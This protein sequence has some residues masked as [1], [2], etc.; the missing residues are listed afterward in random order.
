MASYD[1][2]IVKKSRTWHRHGRRQPL[3]WIKNERKRIE[4]ATWFGSVP[5]L[6]SARGKRR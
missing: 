1:Q 4:R 5:D 2:K 6:F 3:F